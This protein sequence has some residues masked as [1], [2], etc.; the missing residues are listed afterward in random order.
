[1]VLQHLDLLRRKRIVLASASPRRREIIAGVGLHHI[2]VCASGFAEDLSKDEFTCGGDYA[3]RTARRKAEEVVRQLQRQQQQQELGGRDEKGNASES[4]SPFDIL[5]AADT[6]VTM[7]APHG[8][9]VIIEKPATADEA[10][11]MLRL[12]SGTQHEVWSGVVLTV[13]DEESRSSI[14]GDGSD[15]LCWREIKVRTTVKFAPL[16]EEEI[17]A[18]T[19]ERCNWEGKAGGYGIQDT[20][21]C[22]IT[23]I[24]GDYYN[25]MGL[26]LQAVC[27]ELDRLIHDGIVR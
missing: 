23:A 10:A 2:E 26:P 18:Y 9:V 16:V 7:P 19:S 14:G 12:F 4:P 20:A 17:A 13:R 15:R 27:A 3:L 1:M 8:G 21:A 11:A 22:L 6:V 24:D 25:V 5:I